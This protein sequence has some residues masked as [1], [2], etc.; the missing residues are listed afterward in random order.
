[1]HVHAHRHRYF[2][3]YKCAIPSLDFFSPPGREEKKSLPVEA[4]AP[5]FIQPSLSHSSAHP[6]PPLP[7]LPL[8]PLSFTRSVLEFSP[9][10]PAPPAPPPP[11]PSPPL[12]TCVKAWMEGRGQCSA[13]ESGLLSLPCAGGWR[14][15]GWGR[16]W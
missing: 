14:G 9:P 15:W 8:Y 5:A 12:Q 13:G 16:G 10:P 7:P 4:S 2:Y 6:L 3:S 1:M 11:S